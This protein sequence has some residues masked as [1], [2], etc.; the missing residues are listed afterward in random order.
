MKNKRIT[1]VKIYNDI[2]Y[3]CT[4]RCV[5]LLD[6]EE[7]NALILNEEIR[8]KLTTVATVSIAEI[9]TVPYIKGLRLVIVLTKSIRKLFIT[10]PI[11]MV[12]QYTASDTMSIVGKNGAYIEI[13][14]TRDTNG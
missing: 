9:A 6:S 12:S 8:R 1:T 11:E 10:E 13:T 5:G 3:E 4:G 7:Y 2:E 14:E